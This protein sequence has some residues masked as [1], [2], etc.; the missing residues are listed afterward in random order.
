M[1]MFFIYFKAYIKPDDEPGFC[2]VQS[3]IVSDNIEHRMLRGFLP[4][5]P[6]ES[7]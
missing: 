1:Q 7:G 6:F 3:L 2:C 5:H 4:N